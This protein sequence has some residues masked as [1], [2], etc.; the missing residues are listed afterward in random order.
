[1]DAYA[2]IHAFGQHPRKEPEPIRRA[3]IRM[4]VSALYGPEWA[5]R[6]ESSLRRDAD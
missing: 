5:E 2:F 3:V 6:G 1:M 4:W